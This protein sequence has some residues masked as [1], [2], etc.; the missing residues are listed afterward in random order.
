MHSQV[1]KDATFPAPPDVYVQIA[2][3]H[4]T[5]H[6]LD[7]AQSSTHPPVSFTL[8][9]LEGNDLD[10]HFYA[11]G[12]KVA[13]PYLSQSKKLASLTLPPPP[14]DWVIQ[15]GWT[16]YWLGDDGLHESIDY[17]NEEMLVFDVET[18]PNES[19]YAVMACAASPT[20]WYV[21]ISP[22]LMK[23]TTEI[24]QLIPLG[25][26]STS[27]I[28]VGHNV[29]YDR[30]RTLEEY[31]IQRTGTRWL[32]TMALHVAVNGV[33][34]HQRSAWSKYRKQKQTSKAMKDEAV[35][36]V[37]G[38]IN[39]L[40]ESLE[41]EKNAKRRLDLEAQLADLSESLPSLQAIAD[42][43]LEAPWEGD[44]NGQRW[45]ELT[46]VNSLAEV[47]RLHC[48]IEVDKT[49]RDDFMTASPESILSD[50]SSYLT[51]CAK[52][53]AVTHQVFRKI[54]PAFLEKCPN[55]VSFAGV[56]SMGSSFLPVD[57]N[58]E[59]YLEAAEGKYQAL[60][61]KVT[62]AL[63]S[64]AE[65][66]RHLATGD[67]WKEDVWL[68]QLDWTPKTIRSGK[69]QGDYE[70]ELAA[71]ESALPSPRVFDCFSKKPRLIPKFMNDLK[72]LG[73][74][75]PYVRHNILPYLLRLQIHDQPVW[76]TRQYGWHSYVDDPNLPFSERIISPQKARLK[77]LFDRTHAFKHYKTGVLSRP[78]GESMGLW[79]KLVSEENDKEAVEPMRVLAVKMFRMYDPISAKRKDWEPWMKF[80]EWTPVVPGSTEI[81]GEAGGRAEFVPSWYWQLGKAS[82][83]T[84]AD[85]L[86]I[87]VRSRVAPLLFRLKWQGWPLIFS[88]DHGWTFR[89][90]REALNDGTFKTRQ[91]EL[92]FKHAD[93]Q[94]LREASE[95]EG[96]FA[97]FKLPHKDGEDANVGSPLGKTFIKFAA[98]GT[99]SS[100]EPIAGEALEV[101]AQ[102]SYWISARDRIMKQMVVWD[103]YGRQG[104]QSLAAPGGGGK[105][106]MILPQVITMGTVTRRAIEKTWLTASNAKE[107]RVGS[108]LK[109]MV[110][111]PEGYAII[112][113]DVDSEELW[114]SSCMGD[115]Q[116]GLHGATAIG[117]MTLEGTKKAGTDLHSKTASILG[118]TRDQ[119]KVFNY[120][121]IY[122]AGMKHA[123]L[124]LLQSN[125]SMLPEQAQDLAERLYASTKGRNTH[126][127]DLFGHKFWYGGTESFVFNK[128]EQIAISDEP[129]TPV[130]DCGVT[131]ALSKQYLPEKF[132]AD[133][134]PS[135]I[136][137]AVQ[138]SGVDYLH[139]LIVS[140]EHLIKEYDIQARYLI[141][142]HDELRYLVKDEDKYRAVLA[143]QIANLWTR[144][145]F[146]YRLG[147]DDL[148]QSVAFF[149]AV[150]VDRVLRKEVDMPCVTPSQPNPIPPGESLDIVAVLE[151]TNGGSLWKCGSPMAE[152]VNREGPID[153]PGYTA[154]DFLIHRASDAKWLKAQS[155]S[156]IDEIKLLADLGRDMKILKNKKSTARAPKTRKAK[157]ASSLEESTTAPAS[158]LKS[159][160]SQQR[161]YKSSGL[162]SVDTWDGDE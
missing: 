73:V 129:K 104:L 45:E 61:V 111:A 71:L 90:A 22:W 48:G 108:E 134:L 123:M 94:T 138:S 78:R 44:H 130:L 118:I 79:L 125:A 153:V 80:L 7:P 18:L 38:L 113:A 31:H 83:R 51:Y 25:D 95:D 65:S 33:S 86:E 131:F 158:Q 89:V 62:N 26:P 114:I 128:L 55:P 116:F 157:A 88:R 11:I 97:F 54:L 12:S 121:R 105:W 28:V 110:R 137:W 57:E 106:G 41:G 2:K 16:K 34:S 120:S 43:G 122:G 133:Y 20:A 84:S 117:W 59:K 150:D 109:A 148:P 15:S 37:L 161:F 98:D 155:T 66:A 87:S 151:K 102:C 140:M 23:E 46:A 52:D 5:K 93:D 74:S 13:E 139:L 75:H 85:N 53:V 100:P 99:L 32:D 58:W 101:N 63:K 77:S 146:A 14:E 21:W 49:I 70:E 6:S 36:S 29:A 42:V 162:L 3:K 91:K 112:G 103:K 142:V 72:I 149:S 154:P 126:R 132:G 10:S 67:K 30:A 27:R 115:A 24:E 1:F 8:P 50:I 152:W 144:S 47:A 9:P 60:E 40:K 56:C 96:Q 17:P 160:N 4:L 81:L 135:R 69:G 39:E 19:P 119:A 136:N 143:L 127:P 145:I 159:K 107:N 147:M 156:S 124:L 92:S 76:H 64:M 82:R 68:Q 35:D 141:S